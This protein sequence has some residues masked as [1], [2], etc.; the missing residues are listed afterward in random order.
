M[1]K[2]RKLQIPD[3]RSERLFYIKRMFPQASGPDLKDAWHGGRHE[4][5]RRLSGMDALAYERNHH[6]LNGAVTRLSPY[7]RHG[8]ITLNEACNSIRAKYGAKAEKLIFAF[9]WRD[10]WRQVWYRFGDDILSDME[11][12]KVMI[13]HDPLADDIR[14]GTTGL[15]CMDGFI[16]DLLTDGYVHHHARMWFAAYVLHWRKVD[17]RAAAD[18]YQEHLLDGDMA[19]NHLSWQWVASS[20]SSKPYYFNKESLARYTGEKYCAS[21]T[22]TC[23]FDDSYDGLHIKLFP[24]VIPGSPEQHKVDRPTRPAVSTQT[25]L[26]VFV[27]DEMLSAANPIVQQSLHK[28]FVFDDHLHGK[29]SLNRLQFMADCLNEMPEVDVWLG[30]AREVLAE[31]GIGQVITQATPNQEIR[32]MLAPFSPKWQAEP[33]LVDVDISSKRLKRFS[34]YWDKVG[35]LLMGNA[36]Y[37]QP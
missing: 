34:R 32:A 31:R 28:I 16:S 19:S 5:Q 4:A 23:P 20:F 33:K 30:D 25:A 6:F 9:A 26:A 8:C 7:L 36:E 10:Y 18:W 29:W 24:E 13:G 2:P 14:N 15:P 35:P 22:K 17:W 11:A 37:R 27:H 12:A 3:D 1:S 21:C